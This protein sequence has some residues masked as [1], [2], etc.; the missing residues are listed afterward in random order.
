[1][2]AL[3]DSQTLQTLDAYVRYIYVTDLGGAN[4]YDALPSYLSAEIAALD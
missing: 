4:P 3:P 1:V 2:S